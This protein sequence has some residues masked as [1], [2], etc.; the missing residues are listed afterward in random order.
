MSTGSTAEGK[1]SEHNE[2][3]HRLRIVG[4]EVFSES[5][6][7]LNEGVPDALIDE[8]PFIHGYKYGEPFLCP[9]RRQLIAS[10]ASFLREEKEMKGL[11]FYDATDPN[12]RHLSGNQQER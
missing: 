3:K 2:L 4:S 10:Q 11:F 12:C 7:F 6:R 5:A 9:K 1:H 8:R